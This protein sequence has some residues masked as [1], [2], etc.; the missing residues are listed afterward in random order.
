MASATF[1][2]VLPFRRCLN[3]DI[4]L[5]RSSYRVYCSVGI[6]GMLELLGMSRVSWLC[7]VGDECSFICV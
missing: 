5:V 4:V 3:W 1:L 2:C 7:R 6:G